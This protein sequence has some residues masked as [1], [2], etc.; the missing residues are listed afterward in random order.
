MG[1]TI[2]HQKSLTFS[3]HFFELIASVIITSIQKF[4]KTEE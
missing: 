4:N 2:H 3:K 1:L